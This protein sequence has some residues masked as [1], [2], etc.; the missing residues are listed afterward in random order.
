[1]E[2]WI[3]LMQDLHGAPVIEGDVDVSSS[4]PIEF[5]DQRTGRLTQ[6]AVDPTNGKFRAQLPQGG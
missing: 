2:E 5:R 1:V 4:E 6:V 3:W